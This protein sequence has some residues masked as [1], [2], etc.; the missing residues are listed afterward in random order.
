MTKEEFLNQLNPVLDPL[1]KE[2]LEFNNE[3]MGSI[4][5]DLR[6]KINAEFVRIQAKNPTWK[7]NR[8]LRNAGKK[9]GVDFQF[10]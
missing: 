2:T 7:I 5:Q 4:P 10:D 6:K 9:H 3:A 1:T 8:I